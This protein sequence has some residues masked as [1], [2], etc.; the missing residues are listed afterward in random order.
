MNILGIAKGTPQKTYSLGFTGAAA[1]IQ[2]AFICICDQRYQGKSNADVWADIVAQNG[3]NDS[4]T[5][6]ITATVGAKQLTYVGKTLN[7]MGGRYPAGPTGGLKLVFDLYN[8][9]KASAM[10]DCTL[11]NVSHPALVELW[12]YQL[13]QTKVKPEQIANNQDPS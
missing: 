12:C 13:L 7:R 4:I 11:Y 10:L 6:V 3:A 2:G 5:Y 1:S 9:G 8:D